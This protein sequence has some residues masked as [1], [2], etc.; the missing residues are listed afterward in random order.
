MKNKY[1]ILPLFSSPLVFTIIEENTDALNTY[2]NFVKSDID[3]T[4]NTTSNKNFNDKKRILEHYPKIRD[5]LLKKFKEYS[6]EALKYD[7]DYMITTS[8]ITNVDQGGYAQRHFH[9][10]SLYS[11]V[12]YFQD[13]YPEGCASLE[14]TSPIMQ[15]TDFMIS[16]SES[17]CDILNSQSWIVNP[18]PK[19]LIFFPSYVN[20]QILIHRNN[21][22]RRSLA[23]NIIPIGE[24]G[25]G[26][27]TYKNSWIMNM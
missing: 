4:S 20:H 3:S 27:S 9:K 6:N 17:D 10:N 15:L 23:F 21:K 1:E 12:Y 18:Q 19:L 7:N 16:P 5:I 24:Y 14:F 11:G 26:D 8:W 2:Q 25:Q 22:P 13:D